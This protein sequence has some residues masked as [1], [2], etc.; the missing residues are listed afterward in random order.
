MTRR[1]LGKMKGPGPAVHDEPPLVLPISDGTLQRFREK[2]SDLQ[3]RIDGLEDRI[4][5]GL[6]DEDD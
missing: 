3:K 4:V 6:R 1:A 5:Y 2:L